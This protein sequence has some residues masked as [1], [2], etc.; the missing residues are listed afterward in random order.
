MN[1]IAKKKC[2]E[3][4]KKKKQPGSSERST[5]FKR[6]SAKVERCWRFLKPEKEHSENMKYLQKVKVSVT[7]YRLNKVLV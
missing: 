4:Y 5:E 1:I 2:E 6:K 3:K 7:E